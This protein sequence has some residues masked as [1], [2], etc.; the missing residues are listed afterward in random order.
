MFIYLYVG[1]ACR[2]WGGGGVSEGYE[3]V[4]DRCGYDDCV[5]VV[6]GFRECCVEV[7][8]RL[9]VGKCRTVY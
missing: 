5:C 1:G 3:C 2:I 9:T 7:G 4:R 8:V 6:Y